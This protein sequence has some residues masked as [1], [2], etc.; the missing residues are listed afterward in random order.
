MHPTGTFYVDPD[1]LAKEEEEARLKQEETMKLL[2]EELKR[3]RDQNERDRI[4]Q[5]AET[6]RLQDLL[7]EANRQRELEEQRKQKQM[8]EE[9]IILKEDPMS[10]HKVELYF[11]PENIVIMASIGLFLI[12]CCMM[13][14]CYFACSYFKHREEIQ[15][16]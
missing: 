12:L 2:E 5:E 15:E 7:N 13:T 6:Q 4:R 8:E 11:T 1:Q 16:L 3:A 14:T 9:A 10:S